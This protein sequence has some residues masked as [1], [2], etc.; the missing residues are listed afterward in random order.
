V[1][2]AKCLV[3][4]SGNKFG[5]LRSQRGNYYGHVAG[6]LDHLGKLSGQ[7]WPMLRKIAMPR[8][9]EFFYISCD[10][11]KICRKRGKICDSGLIYDINQTNPSRQHHCVLHRRPMQAN[12]RH[13]SLLYTPINHIGVLL[14]SNL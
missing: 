6:V 14:R 11:S 3:I 8:L 1:V 9:Y 13:T 10:C 4:C 12:H 5:K 2:C 7:N